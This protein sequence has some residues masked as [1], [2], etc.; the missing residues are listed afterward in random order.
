MSGVGGEIGA[1]RAG[2]YLQR[3]FQSAGCLDG[4]WHWDLR[5]PEHD[6]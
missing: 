4:I 2:H 5:Q 3:E 6:G 1:G